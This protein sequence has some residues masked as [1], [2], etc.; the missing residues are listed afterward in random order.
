MLRVGG[1][2]FLD[3][4]Q[5]VEGALTAQ[6]RQRAVVAVIQQLCTHKHT[7]ANTYKTTEQQRKQ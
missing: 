5:V 1:P 4:R 6:A 3:I 2:Y 7:H